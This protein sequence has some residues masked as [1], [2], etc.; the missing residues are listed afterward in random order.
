MNEGYEVVE[1]IRGNHE[2]PALA[3]ILVRSGE[4]V[5]SEAV[6]IRAVGSPE[7]VTISDRWHLGSNT[8]SMTA[9][10]AGV[11]VEEGVQERL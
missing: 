5:E 4:V 9:T 11:L 7:P 8:K 2:L 3:A 1:H 10:L 6:G